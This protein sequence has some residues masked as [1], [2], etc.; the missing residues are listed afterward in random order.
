[1]E[2]QSSVDTHDTENLPYVSPLIRIL[3]EKFLRYRHL[4]SLLLDFRTE[5]NIA[6]LEE[7][8]ELYDSKL[9]LV[10]NNACLERNYYL[11]LN[12]TP[13]NQTRST[14]GRTPSSSQKRRFVHRRQI[15]GGS[16]VEIGGD[17]NAEFDADAYQQFWKHNDI[18]VCIC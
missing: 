3:K 10:W 11:Y 8:S 6:I 7:W 16:F 12:W 1:M 5:E 18:S 14:S 9:E 4:Q 13:P 15:H 17:P 2:Y